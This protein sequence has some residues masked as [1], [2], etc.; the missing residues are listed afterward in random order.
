M[1]SPVGNVDPSGLDDESGGTACYLDGL[2][3]DCGTVFGVYDSGGAVICGSSCGPVAI[4]GVGFAFPSY[5]DDDSISWSFS[6]SATEKGITLTDAALA[7]V[8]G[9]PTNYSFGLGIGEIGS[10]DSLIA[11]KYRSTFNKAYGQ[12]L[13]RL[14]NQAC[15]ALYGGQGAST[16]ASTQ[17]EVLPIGGPNLGADTITLGYGGIVRLNSNGP[18]YNYPANA[19]YF[20]YW[21]FGFSGGADVGTVFI[22]HELGHELANVTNFPQDAGNAAL[23]T[24]NTDSVL[25]ACF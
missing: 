8:L 9:L 6:F 19:R 14:K 24:A 15:S 7:E 4:P 12:A 25:A 5:G 2:P 3:M 13:K 1:N 23:I 22:L 16:L 10:P 17:F 11:Q 20:T 18:M 21:K